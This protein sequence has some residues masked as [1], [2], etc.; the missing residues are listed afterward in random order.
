MN[1]E[2]TVIIP[3]FNAVRALELVLAGYL[4]QSRR[5]FEVCIADDGS[6]PEMIGFLK[7]LALQA[8]FPMR[9]VSQLDEGFRKARIVNQ[10]VRTTA[11]PY[12]IFADADCIPHSGFVQEHWQRRE[13]RT[14]LCGR[15]VHLD[16]GMSEGLT[17]KDILDGRLERMTA[18]RLLEA[19][20]RRG[21]HWD[22]GV[23]IRNRFLHR[24]INY[25]T[26]TLLGSN[27][28][29]EKSLFEEINGYNEDFEGYGGEDTELEYRLR[30]AGVRFRWVR[31]L[32]IQ[33]HLHH[34]PRRGAPDNLLAFARTQAE[35]KAAC[36]NGLQKLP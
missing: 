9:H 34:P 16:P 35:G 11:A 29:L 27:F 7:D 5:D 10:A 26:P 14:V 1:P 28:S 19:L 33:Y 8:F 25:K 22:E 15:R 31:H 6:G 36:R 32:A 23:L 18:A 3:V 30:L 17:R 2:I 4:R 21:G 12:L 20:L 13:S 24:W